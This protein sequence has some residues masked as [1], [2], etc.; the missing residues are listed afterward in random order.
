MKVSVGSSETDNEQFCIVLIAKHLKV[1]NWDSVYLCLALAGHE[2]VIL[3]VGTY[4]ACLIVLL[5]TA[6]YVLEA[7]PAR[8]SPVANA[9]SITHIRC[10]RA[11]QILWNIR[12]IDG[13]IVFQVWQLESRRA[14]SHKGIRH[15]DYR[16]HVFQSHFRGRES[17]FE[18]VGGTGSGNDR[19][20]ALAVTTKESLQEVGLFA[21][22]WKT[23]CRT[24]SLHIEHDEGQFHDDCEVHRLAL[25]ADAGTGSTGHTKCS[26]E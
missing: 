23:R 6:K 3:R 24:A 7:F 17:H 11:F 13:G 22:R 1:R 9:L 15:E 20:W 14:V 12:R 8:H 18:A 5:K 2:V 16:R 26:S 21:L 10:P 19:H 4:R 25:Q